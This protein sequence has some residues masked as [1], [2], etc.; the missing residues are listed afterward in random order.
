[1][2]MAVQ[3]RRV[4]LILPYRGYCQPPGFEAGLN[5]YPVYR[6]SLPK[7]GEQQSSA[8]KTFCRGFSDIWSPTFESQR[9]Y[10]RRYLWVWYPLS[11]LVSS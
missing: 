1:M 11:R 7:Y 5:S 2:H 10:S 6:G 9:V 3:A 4:E 8:Q